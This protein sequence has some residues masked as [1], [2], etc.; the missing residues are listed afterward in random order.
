MEPTRASLLADYSLLLAALSD[1]K[2]TKVRDA[3]PP[4]RDLFGDEGA[5]AFLQTEQSYNVQLPLRQLA[6]APSH[7]L[8]TM[9]VAR[10]GLIST[11]GAAFSAKGSGRVN[12]MA[13]RVA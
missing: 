8:A 1:A 6:A 2:L 7:P 10:A 11:G 12:D 5:A 13:G 4:A 3:L 9:P